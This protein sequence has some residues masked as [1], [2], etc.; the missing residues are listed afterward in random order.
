MNG[1]REEI[2]ANIKPDPSGGK[3]DAKNGSRRIL[4]RGMAAGLV[5]ALGLIAVDLTRYLSRSYL[6]DAIR[7][8]MPEEQALVLLRRSEVYCYTYPTTSYRC[9]FDDSWK[10]YTIS[11]SEPQHIVTRKEFAFKQ[12]RSWLRRGPPWWTQ[13]HR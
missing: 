7:L 10:V 3:T 6:F 13:V 12:H 8:G 4:A 1:M 2:H 5:I 9:R 11:I